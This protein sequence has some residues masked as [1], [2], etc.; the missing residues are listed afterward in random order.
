MKVE[1]LQKI[2]VKKALSAVITTGELGE[3]LSR[4]T[5]EQ[6]VDMVLLLIVSIVSKGCDDK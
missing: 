3:Y 1:A 2:L 5:L 4:F 6:K